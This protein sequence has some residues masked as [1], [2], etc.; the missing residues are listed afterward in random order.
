M[1]LISR[2]C[3]NCGESIELYDNK[4]FGFCIYCGHKIILKNNTVKPEGVGDSD[5]MK[6]WLKLA[7]VA[8]ETNNVRDL[9]KYAGKIIEADLENAKGWVLKGCASAIELNFDDAAVYWKT[10][11][12]YASTS[13]ELAECSFL[14]AD[15]MQYSL[16]EHT[17][18]SLNGLNIDLI[19]DIIMKEWDAEIDWDY[20]EILVNFVADS[21][22]SFIERSIKTINSSV[23]YRVLTFIWA[24]RLYVLF[25][26]MR[27]D[28]LLNTVRE[29]RDFADKCLNYT[30]SMEFYI[31]EYDGEE[32]FSRESIIMGIKEEASLTTMLATAYE[33][34]FADL[35]DEDEET[36]IDYWIDDDNDYGKLLDLLTEGIVKY[37]EGVNDNFDEFNETGKNAGSSVFGRKKA[38]RGQAKKLLGKQKVEAYLE[39]YTNVE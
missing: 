9:K 1:G 26:E 5:S 23:F 22:E 3:P 11:V 24:L 16:I 7:E 18:N 15:D 14:I 35:S 27:C 36:I 12:S 17:K 13:D 8:R 37:R 39:E 33:K 30:K 4:E 21:L 38:P 19:I 31:P 25:I 20:T 32:Y 2:Y 34:Y 10:G 6:K 28:I 29:Y